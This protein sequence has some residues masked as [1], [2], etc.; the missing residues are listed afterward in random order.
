MCAIEDP[1][2]RVA[3]R[4]LA[5]LRQAGIAVERGLM[6][7]AAHWIAAGHILRVTER[8]PLVTAKLALD[9]DGAV[10]RGGHGTAGCGR[11]AKAARAQGI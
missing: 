9:A 6:A 5:R 8:R 11:R 7:E 10:P 1:D 2:P 3:G 4:G